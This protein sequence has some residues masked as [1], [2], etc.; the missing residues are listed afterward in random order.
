MF[1]MGRFRGDVL[2]FVGGRSYHNALLASAGE[3]KYDPHK[4][5]NLEL[6]LGGYLCGAGPPESRDSAPLTVEDG[7]RMERSIRATFVQSSHERCQILLN[8]LTLGRG[9]NI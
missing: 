9:L 3:R 5:V 4:A 7:W 8:L 6:K 1:V 2:K